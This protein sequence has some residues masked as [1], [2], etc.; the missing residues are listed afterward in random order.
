[1]NKLNALF[2]AVIV[3]PLEEQETQY[4]SIIVPDMGKDKNVHGTVVAVG[5]G[6]HTVTG[7]FIETMVKIGQVV[8][9]PTMGFTKLEHNGDEYWIGSEKQLLAFIE[10]EK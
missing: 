10:E 5:P 1:M 7:T 8:I 2:D 4:G 3:K 6:V 9:M